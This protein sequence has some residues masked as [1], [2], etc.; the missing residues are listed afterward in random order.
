[1]LSN[2]EV[3]SYLL[4]NNYS[5]A[6]S[7]IN[8][9]L[10]I[11][12]VSRRHRNLKVI[13]KKGQCYL[14]KQGVGPEGV[15][16]IAHEAKVYEL[17]TSDHQNNKFADFLPRYY[18]YDAEQHILVL[19][20]LNDW[21]DLREYY[22]SNGRFSLS[23]A[24]EM[25]KALSTL[26]RITTVESN[27]GHR[28]GKFTDTKPWITFLYRPDARIFRDVS[29]A[30][31]Q[32]IKIIQK[33]GEFGELIDDLRQE[34]RNQTLVHFDI[35]WDN[36]L[37]SSSGNVLRKKRIKLV[38]WELAGVGDPCWDLGSVFNDYLS[39]WLFSIPITGE[40]PPEKFHEL[41]RYPLYRMKPA[42][43]SFW[44]SYMESMQLDRISVHNWLL[45]SVKYAALRLIQSAFEQTQISAQLT[46]SAV[47]I[48]QLSMN[49]LCRPSEA[50]SRLLG[51]PT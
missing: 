11:T 49:I 45:R 13:N 17:L 48:L 41:A 1:V 6:E 23:V 5:T 20:F 42:I 35:K 27:F 34:W 30:S 43:H 8:S 39:F 29:G 25:G 9:D 47:C 33:F 44:Q 50:A 38:D 32:L 28:F 26:H 18:G 16:A 12:D 19:E 15:A 37:V 14:L 21:Q 4:K 36:C 2:R 3:I 40:T 51:I 10:T 24:A 31:V 46:G 22:T 7:I